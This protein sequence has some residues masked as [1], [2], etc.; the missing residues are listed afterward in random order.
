VQSVDVYFYDSDGRVDRVEGRDANA[1]A[2]RVRL[3]EYLASGELARLKYVEVDGVRCYEQR[4]KGTTTLTDLYFDQTGTYLT[5]IRGQI[6]E[7]ADL[8]HG[9]GEVGD[10]LAYGIAL[11]PSEST[12]RR[13][14][15][16]SR[17]VPVKTSSASR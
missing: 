1:R 9:W 12:S 7:D 4:Q 5:G 3:H 16:M 11:S 17:T 8:P 2:P 14:S 13:I 6:P 15:E 10:G